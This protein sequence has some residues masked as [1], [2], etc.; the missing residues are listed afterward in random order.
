MMRISTFSWAAACLLLW[1]RC[2]GADVIL[3]NGRIFTAEPDHPYADAIAIRDDRIVA[4]GALQTVESQVGA[5]AKRVDL[6]R[7]FLMPG[8][9]DAHAHPFDGGASLLAPRYSAT[10]GSVPNLVKFVESKLDDKSAYRGDVLV[11]SDIDLGLWSHVA[12][13]DAALSNGKFGKQR[14]VLVGSDGHTS[15]AN[16]PTRIKAGIT[17]AFIRKLPEVALRSYGHDAQMNPNGFVLDAGQD[18][19][20]KSLPRVPLDAKIAAGRAALEYM[21]SVGIT[22]WL[23]AAVAGVVGGSV[24]LSEKDPGWLPVYATLGRQGDLPAHVVGYP[25]INPELGNVLIDVVQRLQSQFLGFPYFRIPGLKFFADGV[26]ETPSQNASSTKP[27]VG[28]RD[29]KPLFTP[30]K[31]ND[32]VAEAFRR[33]LAVH[34]HAIGDLAVKD[35]F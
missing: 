18:K 19:N 28:G 10:D 32:L 26:V 9:I 33:G 35:S 31:T 23:D 8:M 4:V 20:E 24:P 13:I 21:H 11:I 29:V 6:G 22:G 1:G 7:K 3:F 34:I 16:R 2:F 12:D 27:Y 5:G 15:W 25:V 17:Q 30:S 14:I